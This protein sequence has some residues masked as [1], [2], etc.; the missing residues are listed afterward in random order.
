MIEL[1]QF[2]SG[3]EAFSD[4]HDF[5]KL[6]VSKDFGGCFKIHATGPAPGT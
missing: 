5:S 3:L 4:I 1:E 6:A 2:P